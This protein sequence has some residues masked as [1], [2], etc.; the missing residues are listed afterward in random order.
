MVNT[1]LAAIQDI[2][3]QE[4]MRLGL[5]L[6]DDSPI[7]QEDR[8]K[9]DKMIERLTSPILDSRKVLDVDDDPSSSDNDDDLLLSISLY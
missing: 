2:I 9:Y 7:N 8:N 4:R 3:N 6:V 1:V 5:S